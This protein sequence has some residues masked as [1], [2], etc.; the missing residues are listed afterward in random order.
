MRVKQLALGL[1]LRD[2]STFESFYPGKNEQVIAH[3]KLVAKGLSDQF[4][5]LWG[6]KGVGC[7]HLL[8]GA[9]RWAQ[10]EGLSSVYYSLASSKAK[11]SMLLGLE[12]LDLVCLDD[13]QAISGDPK[14]E[15]ALFHT[16]NSL[17]T[18]GTRL[19]I[20][21]YHP[22]QNLGIRL[23][24][25]LSRLMWGVTYQ[26]HQLDDTEL[27]AALTLRAHQRGLNLPQEVG[28]FIIRRCPRS[29][30]VLYSILDTLDEASMAAQR[31]LTIPFAK[32]ILRL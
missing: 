13:I 2:D 31:K 5:F 30:P 21:G 6:H 19:I 28:E 22:P 20:A 29:M 10:E 24:D 27:L 17:K 12:K 23:P 9:C 25:L 18:Q 8:Q 11:V 32:Q 4:V 3:L 14:W 26:V 1:G 16:Y 7:T 15:E